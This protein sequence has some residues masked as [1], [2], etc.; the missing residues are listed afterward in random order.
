M[1]LPSQFSASTFRSILGTDWDHQAFVAS[2]FTHPPHPC[3]LTLILCVYYVYLN[4][5][6]T[7]IPDA[8]LLGGVFAVATYSEQK[9]DEIVQWEE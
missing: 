5:I 7:G 8:L 9:F 1:T 4:I 2:T 3:P 6:L